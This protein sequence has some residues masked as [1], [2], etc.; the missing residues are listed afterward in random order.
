[1][2]AYKFVLI[3]IATVDA[4]ARFRLRAARGNV[5]AGLAVLELDKHFAQTDK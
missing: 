5:A 4:E 3:R 1:M 2:T